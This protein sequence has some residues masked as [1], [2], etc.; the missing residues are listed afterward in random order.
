[1]VCS[2]DTA[3]LSSQSGKGRL[4]DASAFVTEGVKLDD[5]GITA[6]K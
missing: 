3:P 2:S 1:M 6:E 4:V 5:A